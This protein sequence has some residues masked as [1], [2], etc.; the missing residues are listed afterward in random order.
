M[1]TSVIRIDRNFKQNSSQPVAVQN[2]NIHKTSL[3][4]APKQKTNKKTRQP[5][6]D[7]DRGRG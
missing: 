4:T 2:Q 5:P 6:K 3:G 1:K 7:Q